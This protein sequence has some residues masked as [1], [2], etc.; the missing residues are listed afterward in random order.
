[1]LTASVCELRY[2]DYTNNN[3]KF[4]RAYTWGRWGLTHWGRIGTK[5]QFKIV[6][7][8]EALNKLDEKLASGYNYST[9]WTDFQV[10]DVILRN[11][12]H[13]VALGFTDLASRANDVIGRRVTG[14]IARPAGIPVKA[15]P[16]KTE[17]EIQD[18]FAERLLAMKGKYNKAEEPTPATPAEPEAPKLDP[19]SVEGRLGAALAAAKTTASTDA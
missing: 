18:E 11:C 7:D 14:V 3:H 2:E 13:N 15:V 16:E 8:R 10:S 19:E 9:N 6:N 12:E 4:Y 5:G 17:E 1:M